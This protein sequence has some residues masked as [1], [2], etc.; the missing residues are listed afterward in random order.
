MRDRLSTLATIHYGKSPAEVLD[1]DGPVPIV[2]TGGTYG[3]ASEAMFRGPAVVVPRKGSLGNP[4]LLKAPFWPVDTTYAVVP[5]KDVDEN[6]LYYNLLHFDL[7]KLNEATGVPSISREWLSKITFF[8][9]GKDEQP[10]IGE[11][12][13]AVDNAIEKTEALIA[14][15]QQIKAGLM[16]DL[17]TRGVTADGKLRPPRE[18]APELY[19]ETPIGWIPKAWE[20][21]PLSAVSEFITSGSRGWAA[22]YAL[23]GPLFIR[24]GNLTREHP[25]FRWDSIQRVRPPRDAEGDRTRVVTGDILVSIT[26]DL[27]ISAVVG[28]CLGEAYVNQH[29]ALIRPVHSIVNCRFVGHYL[30]TKQAQLFFQKLNDSGAKAGLN[31]PAVGRYLIPKPNDGCEAELIRLMLDGADGRVA[32]LRKDG[33]KLRLTR[34]GLMHDL[35]TGKVRVAA[36]SRTPEPACV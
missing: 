35:L 11:I 26:A 19:Q 2:G 23:E 3:Q 32:A 5:G 20:V 27:G 1:E 6:W 33:E 34:S 9:P 7:T 22:Y 10:K 12:L 17:F 15:Y 13:R 4:Q 31:L 18:H 25:N 36:D 29:I 30:A 24:I 16:H 8:N 21:V 28:D 14:K